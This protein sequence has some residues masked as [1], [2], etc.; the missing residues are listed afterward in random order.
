MSNEEINNDDVENVETN[1]AS[2]VEVELTD[3][4]AALEEARK[5]AD[6][7]RDQFLRAQ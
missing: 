2:D 3:D 4:A 7:Y 5:K 6:E 1:E